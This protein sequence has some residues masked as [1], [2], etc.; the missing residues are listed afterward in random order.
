MIGRSHPHD[1]H[2][3]HDDDD[4]DHDKVAV[5]LVKGGGEQHAADYKKLNPMEQVS[6]RQV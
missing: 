6:A 4:H 5:R 1:D 3:N 2:N